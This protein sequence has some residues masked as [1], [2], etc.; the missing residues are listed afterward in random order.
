MTLLWLSTTPRG[1]EVLPEVYW[2][3]QM[4][5]SAAADGRRRRGSPLEHVRRQE[6]PEV[7]GLGARGL[8]VGPEPVDG[9]DRPGLAAPEDPGLELGV[10]GG[11]EGHGH[12]ADREGAEE[13]EEELLAGREDD[14]HLVAGPEAPLAEGPGVA[15]ARR[16]EPPGGEGVPK[17]VK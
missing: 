13:G 1:T 2:R 15:E 12:G 10:E 14:G 4:S 9:D 16:V 17:S 8:D 7:R 5:S 6:V 11:V 3:K